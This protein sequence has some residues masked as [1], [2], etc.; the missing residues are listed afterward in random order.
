MKRTALFLVMALTAASALAG[1][2][3]GIFGTYW[4]ADDTDDPAIGGGVKLKAPLMPNLCV[5]LRGSYLVEFLDDSD[6]ESIIPLEAGLVIEFPVADQ[7]TIF[8]GGGAGYFISPEYEVDVPGWGSA[9]L[10]LDDEVGYYV[11]AGAELKLNE[12]VALFAEAK[13][14]AVEF[15][16]A[17]VDG[18]DV[19]FEDSELKGLGVNA[20]LMLLW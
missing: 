8:A 6:E 12:S 14:T 20:G 7:L 13:Y 3:L 11:V 1:G 16:G 19:D 9:D 4:D 15:D 17:E 5:E 2:G 18:T 10:D